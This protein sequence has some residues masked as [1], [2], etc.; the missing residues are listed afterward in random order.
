V[1]GTA[2]PGSNLLL[3]VTQVNAA[4]DQLRINATPC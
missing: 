4:A 1:D 2:E 3:Q